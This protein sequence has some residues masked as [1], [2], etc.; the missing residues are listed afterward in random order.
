MDV[1]AISC[2]LLQR[3]TT[4]GM[5]SLGAEGLEM[6]GEGGFGKGDERQRDVGA[7]QQSEPL[8]LLPLISGIKRVYLQ[9]TLIDI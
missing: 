1:R 7:Q 8:T 6:G 9:L 5:R 4:L 3:T 2:C